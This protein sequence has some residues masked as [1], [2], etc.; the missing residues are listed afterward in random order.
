MDSNFSIKPEPK[1]LFFPPVG[2]DRLK[3]RTLLAGCLQFAFSL[4]IRRLFI[5]K[6]ARSQKVAVKRKGTRARQDDAGA[7]LGESAHNFRECHNNLPTDLCLSSK[8]RMRTDIERWG[9]RD[10]AVG[11]RDGAVGSRDG[12]VGS[13][14]GAVGSRDGAVGRTLASH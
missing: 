2:S 4:K 9:S 10:G 8:H 14:D 1:L 13:R 11:S 12:A 7:H 6:R 5:L 3:C